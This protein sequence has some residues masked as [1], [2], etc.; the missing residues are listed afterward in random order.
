MPNTL[1]SIL[2]NADDL[3]RLEPEELGGV[4]LEVVPG[5]L[6]NEMFQLEALL[7]QLFPVIGESY[8]SSLRRPV[9]VAIAEALSWLITQGLLILDPEQPAAWYRLTR[10][11]RTLHTRAD[12]EA[13]RKGRIL[14]IDLLPPIFVEKVWPL[15]LRGDH[16]IAVFQSF[17]EVEVA[18][19]R[20]ANAKGANFPDDLVGVALMRKAFHPETGLLTNLNT[21]I[22][23]REA[24]GALFAGA[25]GHAKNPAGHQD[26]GSP[27]QEAAR[28]VVFAAHLLD[29]VERRSA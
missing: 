18:V 14:P 28:L 21:P 11:A 12:V 3:L 2:R 24:E 1:I 26:V 6:Q 15:F 20:A 19:R 22:A 5:L 10:R 27:P 29:I 4:I 8:P 9:T 23:E 13:F 17:K 7:S 25:I 16:D